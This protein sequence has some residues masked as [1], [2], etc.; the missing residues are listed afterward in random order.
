MSDTQERYQPGAPG[1]FPQGTPGINTLGVKSPTLER[2]LDDL[3][4]FIKETMKDYPLFVKQEGWDDQPLTRGAEVSQMIMP[5]ADEEHER[6]PY[7][8]LQMLNGSDKRDNSGRM[9]SK[10]NVR[11]V[12]AIYNKDRLE[13]RLQLLRIVQ[14]IRFDLWDAGIIGRIF[15]LDSLEFL[16]YPD[17]TEWHHLGE[18]ST[19]WIIPSVQRDLTAVINRQGIGG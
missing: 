14:K 5:D 19:D 10:A 17:E 4:D 1:G 3:Q 2:L 11:I 16:I 7:I 15:M 8:L 18:M 12:I 6:I 13:G 9:V